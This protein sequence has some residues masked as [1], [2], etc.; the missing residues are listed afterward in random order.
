MST[1]VQLTILDDEPSPQPIASV[2][3][4]VYTTGGTLVTSG[5]TNGS[6]VLEFMVPDATYNLLFYKQGVSILPRQPQQIIVDSSLSNDFSLTG[7]V[8]TMPESPDQL[9]CRVSGN[10]VGV[11]GLPIHDLRVSFRPCPDFSVVGGN[12]VSP[13]SQ[14]EVKATDAGYFQFD[15]LR[16]LKYAAYLRGVDSFPLLGIDPVALNVIGPDLPA[17]SLVNLLFPLPILVEFTQDSI[18]IPLAGGPDG[19]STLGTIHYSDDSSS[20]TDP[21][22]RTQ[23]P[24][25]ATLNY[26]YSDPTLFSIILSNGSTQVTPYKTGTGTVTMVRVLPKSIFWPVPPIFTSETLTVT[27]T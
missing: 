17:M 23:Q 19:S 2:V 4:Q 3:V 7:H 12:L 18:S 16:G 27:I 1:P 15:L 24:P 14:I 6:G 11:D 21:S 5:T 20:G 26:V 25:F 13:Q 10:L 22:S 8:S 9:R